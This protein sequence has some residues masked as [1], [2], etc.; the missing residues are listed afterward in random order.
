MKKLLTH[1]AGTR[2]LQ[3][4]SGSRAPRGHLRLKPT[5]FCARRSVYDVVQMYVSYSNKGTESKKLGKNIGDAA[6]ESCM[7]A[8]SWRIEQSFTREQ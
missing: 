6:L 5:P 3:S 1:P 8:L 2:G 4:R 7:T